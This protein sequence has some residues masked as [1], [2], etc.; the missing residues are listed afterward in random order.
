MERYPFTGHFCISLEIRIKI[1]LNKNFFL[2]LSK[3]LR[4]ERP[5]GSIYPHP[6]PYL[7][8]LS[9][10]PVMEPSLQVPIMES[11]GERC[12]VPRALLHSSFTVPVYEPPSRFQVPLS[13][14]GTHVEKD[15]RI[16]SLSLHIFQGPQ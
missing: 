14:K 9:G 2:L 13:R 16:R 8:Y 4:K 15:V 7:T 1:P 5:C 3:A 10:S 11:L 12:P 6:E